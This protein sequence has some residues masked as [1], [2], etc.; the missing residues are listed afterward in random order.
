MSETSDLRNIT[1]F[2]GQNFQLW[3]FQI[4]AIF[5]A[6]DLLNIVEGIEAKPEVPDDS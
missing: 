1:K 5:V 3:K 2:D 6:Y 4:K